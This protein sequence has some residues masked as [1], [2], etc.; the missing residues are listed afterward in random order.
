MHMYTH[1]LTQ[2]VPYLYFLPFKHLEAL[3]ERYDLLIQHLAKV[4]ISLLYRNLTFSFCLDTW[5]RDLKT[6]FNIEAIF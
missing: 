5:L 3:I 1:T 4:E 6:C 2:S